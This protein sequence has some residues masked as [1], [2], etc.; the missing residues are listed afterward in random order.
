[1]KL[2]CELYEDFRS[3]FKSE[4][5]KLKIDLADIRRKD[6]MSK[7]IEEAKLVNPIRV[8]AQQVQIDNN[9]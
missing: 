3:E 6:T 5:D 8:I 4:T 1:M 2:L 7:W 9:I